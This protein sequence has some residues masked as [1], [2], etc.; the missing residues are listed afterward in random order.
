MCRF[1]RL[2]VYIYFFVFFIFSYTNILMFFFVF[3]FSVALHASL[4]DIVLTRKSF[5]CSRVVGPGNNFVAFWVPVS[6]SSGLSP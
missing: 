1:L 4:S 3:V 6:L 5:R 2:V